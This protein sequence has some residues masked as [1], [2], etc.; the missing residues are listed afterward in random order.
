M[1][2]K[3]WIKTNWRQ[4]K[5]FIFCAFIFMTRFHFYANQEFWNVLLRQKK[6]TAAMFWCFMSFRSFESLRI[7]IWSCYEPRYS[8]RQSFNR[9]LMKFRWEIVDLQDLWRARHDFQCHPICVDENIARLY[10]MSRTYTR[11]TPPHHTP[12]EQNDSTN[13]FGY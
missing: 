2:W 7:Y 6:T 13:A 12:L 4:E 3:E 9:G 11:M 10:G 8:R 5:L 1:N